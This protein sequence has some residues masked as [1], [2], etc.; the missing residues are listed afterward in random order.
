MKRR[1][2]LTLL[3][4]ATTAWPAAARAQQQPVTPVIGFLNSASPVG[5]ADRVRAFHQGLGES[6]YVEGRNVA[7]EYRWA[8]GQ[9][10]RLPAMAAD[11]I[12]RKVT[13][14][15]ANGAAAMAAKG[16]TATVPIIFTI[17]DDRSSLDLSRASTGPAAMPPAWPCW[18]LSSRQSDSNC[19]TSCFLPPVSLPCS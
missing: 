17:G 7:V 5:Y 12:G 19:C 4:G 11:L 16:V 2:F 10:D 13:V 9:N 3:G 15:A 6:G 8:D 18:T 1:E 14:I